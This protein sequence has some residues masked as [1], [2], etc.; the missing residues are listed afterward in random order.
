MWIS[1]GGMG[2]QG[3]RQVIWV[4]TWIRPCLGCRTRTDAFLILGNLAQHPLPLKFCCYF[5]NGRVQYSS[6]FGAIEDVLNL[7]LSKSYRPPKWQNSAADDK[8]VKGGT[9]KHPLWCCFSLLI[10]PKKSNP[11]SG[12]SPPKK[13]RHFHVW[14]RN[15]HV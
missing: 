7:N 8:I 3:Y 14:Q 9:M 15:Y 1:I 10:V 6:I 5:V 4:P 11:H 13:C 12:L 2:T